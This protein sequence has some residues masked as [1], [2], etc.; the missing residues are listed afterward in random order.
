MVLHLGTRRYF[1]VS[2]TALLILEALESPQTLQALVT[3][4]LDEY[5]V[6]PQE[7]S[8]TVVEFLEQ[9]MASKLVSIEQ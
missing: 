2:E 3:R 8:T 7:A 4:I 9:C 5:D 1:S 6:S